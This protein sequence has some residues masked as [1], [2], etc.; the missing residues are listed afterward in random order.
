MADELKN[1]L[2]TIAIALGILV[3]ATGAWTTVVVRGTDISENKAVNDRQTECLDTIEKNITTLEIDN[4][5]HDRDFLTIQQNIEALQRTD[6]ELG[7]R[8]LEQQKIGTER[9]IEI[10]KR[11]PQ[12][13]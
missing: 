1:K 11:L 5:V 13:Q 9:Y 7:K 3:T 4:Q 10:L 2:Q 6:V 12:E 8:A